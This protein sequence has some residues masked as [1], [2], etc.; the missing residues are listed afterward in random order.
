MEL[1]YGFTDAQIHYS[2]IEPCIIAEEYLSVNE[3]RQS[4]I[5]YK[6][7]CFEGKPEYILVV[8]DRIIRG[9]GR[10]YKTSAYDLDWNNI[11]DRALNKDI[12]HFDGIDLPRPKC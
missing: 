12:C 8:H 11:S 3:K 6:V 2:R 9:P 4:L 7:W 5:D 10:N 1:K